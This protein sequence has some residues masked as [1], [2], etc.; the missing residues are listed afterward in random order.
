MSDSSG[1]WYSEKDIKAINLSN[2]PELLD[3]IKQRPAFTLN[4]KAITAL[5]HYL[6]G[7]LSHFSRVDYAPNPYIDYMHLEAWL[8][9]KYSAHWEASMA[10]LDVMYLSMEGG[11][12][13]HAYHKFFED[14]DE[15]KKVKN[16]VV[17]V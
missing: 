4:V 5:V 3:Y 1:N 15:Y 10:K 9:I 16:I 2:L 17:P 8:S 6:K 13:E 11:N 7:Y 12:E 14:W